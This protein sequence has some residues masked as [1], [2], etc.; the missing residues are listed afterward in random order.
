VKEW[1]CRHCDRRFSSK[2]NMLIHEGVRHTGNLPYNCD[3]CNKAF[4]RKK[5]RDDHIGNAHGAAVASIE[6]ESEGRNSP[7]C[8]QD[9]VACMDYFILCILHCFF[10]SEIFKKLVYH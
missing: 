2:N 10:L 3:V 8:Y 6:N 1:K 7:N 9:F 5:A 4:T